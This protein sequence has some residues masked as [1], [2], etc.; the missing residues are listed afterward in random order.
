MATATTKTRSLTALE[1]QQEEVASK[2]ISYLPAFFVIALALPFI[3]D[4]GTLRMSVYRF[5]LLIVF[6]PAIIGWMFGKAGPKRPSDYFFIIFTIWCQIAMVGADGFNHSIEPIGMLAIETLG[7]YF[8]GR[9]FIR[10]KL[11]FRAMAKTYTGVLLVLLPFAI[12]EAISNR[13][14]LIEI[15]SK[16]WKS[17]PAVYL[18]RPGRL[19][20]RRS[21]VSFEH[22]ILFGLFCSYG[23]GLAGYALER[24]KVGVLGLLR[25][26]VA[27]ACTFFSLSTGAYLA[28]GT[29]ILFTGWEFLTR[30]VKARWKI[31]IIIVAIAYVTVDMLSNRS[32]FQVFVSYMTFD[33]GTSYNR[34][35]IWRFGT[36]QL[37]LTPLF[38]IG[39]TGDWIR[40]W[41][42]H[43]S[44]D[45]FWL[46]LA[47][48]HGILAFV[49]FASAVVFLLRD[50]GRAVILDQ[51]ARNMRLG[52]MF[53]LISMFVAI[54]S[55]HLWNATYVLFMFLLGAG[56]W[57]ADH[58]DEVPETT[59]SKVAVEKDRSNQK[60]GNFRAATRPVA[61][62]LPS[63][64]GTV[65]ARSKLRVKHR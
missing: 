34:V 58:K 49:L 47:V 12:L 37:W 21:Q 27:I 52:W 36:Q 33:Q 43:P 55:V 42:M 45:N 30:T 28:V 26:V 29:Q 31:L 57:F 18:D 38:G 22:P 51:E 2:R 54:C 65:K 35:L 5:V 3:I 63:A 1:L 32:P 15:S 8:L 40:P 46:V 59:E 50:I 19:G 24:G 25:A 61:H 20:L 4:I 62:A 56:M 11:Q 6:F 16:I 13:S 14:I 41:W 17:L 23:Y 64:S 44:M 39:F 10:N 7:A 53:A 60:A 48:R 9:T